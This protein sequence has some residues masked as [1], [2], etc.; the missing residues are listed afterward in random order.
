[1]IVKRY[2]RWHRGGLGAHHYRARPTRTAAGDRM[3]LAGGLT[4]RVRAER[5]ERAALAML[6]TECERLAT[7][8]DGAHRGH[9]TAQHVTMRAALKR[10]TARIMHTVRIRTRPARQRFAAAAGHTRTAARETAAVAARTARQVGAHR[11]VKGV[12]DAAHNLAAS[13]LAGLKAYERTRA[14]GE[15]SIWRQGMRVA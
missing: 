6:R 9:A 13:A 2:P 14:A 8:L 7:L 5:L 3:V 12:N 11:H 15:N 10:D 4:R 1:M